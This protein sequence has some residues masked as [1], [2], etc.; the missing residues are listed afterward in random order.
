M[1]CRERIALSQFLKIRG[2]EAVHVQRGGG[3]GPVYDPGGDLLPD[4][5][6]DADH[7][8]HEND[9]ARQHEALG[10]AETFQETVDPQPCTDT[11]PCIRV[12]GHRM[13]FVHSALWPYPVFGRSRKVEMACLLLH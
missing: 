7:P 11:W 13:T 3:R 1:I 4:P 2:D 6:A 5:P 9:E 10:D 12:P 8:Q